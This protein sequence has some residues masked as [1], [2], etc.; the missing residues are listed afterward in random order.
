[1]PPCHAIRPQDIPGRAISLRQPYAWAVAHGHMPIIQRARWNPSDQDRHYT[2]DIAIHAS[3]TLS[4]ND[5]IDGRAFLKS[6]GVDCPAADQLKL[7]GIIGAVEITG[8]TFGTAEH[9]EWMGHAP[10][11]YT[12]DKPRVCL[13][14]LSKGNPRIFKWTYSQQKPAMP[15]WTNGFEN[16]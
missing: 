11:A 1:M 13:L 4:Q 14:C 15:L 2:G 8:K 3:H 10:W 12:I 16:E 9:S 5:Y 6:L 7:G